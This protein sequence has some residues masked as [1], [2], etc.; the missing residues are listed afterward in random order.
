MSF[1]ARYHGRCAACEESIIPGEHVRYSEDEV[2][3]HD[4][5]EEAS[6]SYAAPIEVCPQCWLTKPCDCE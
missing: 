6:A 3:V 4:R 2:L 1:D 5:C